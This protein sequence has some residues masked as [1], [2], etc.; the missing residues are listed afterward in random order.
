[1]IVRELPADE[2]DKLAH[3]TAFGD[4]PF[5]SPFTARVI[6]AEQEDRIVGLWVAQ[7]Q[8]HIEPVWIDAAHRSSTLPKRMFNKLLE[9]LDSCSLKSAFCF[10]DRPEIADYLGRLGLVELPY[11]TFQLTR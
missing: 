9:L 2:W 10:A 6:V 1:M 7:T 11:R 5:P 4:K 3:I 8:V